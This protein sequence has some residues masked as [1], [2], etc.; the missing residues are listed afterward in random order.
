MTP[1]SLSGRQRRSF[2]LATALW[3]PVLLVAQLRA[4]SVPPLKWGKVTPAEF[5]LKTCPYDSSASAVVLSDYGRIVFGYGVLHIERHKRTK[6]LNR[7]GL[8]AATV[9]I[10]Y[11]AE[12]NFEKITGLKAQAIAMDDKGRPVVRELSPREVFTLDHP[13]NWKEKRFTFPNVKAGD[14]L[15]Y[16][17]TTLSRNFYTLESWC[18]QSDIPTLHSEL[19][20]EKP[21]GLNYRI[22]LQG[23]ALSAKYAKLTVNQWSLDNLPALAREPHVAYPMDYAERITFQVAMYSKPDGAL[24]DIK[25]HA[26]FMAHRDHARKVLAEV[27]GG[28]DTETEKV[29]KIH[30]Y[31]TRTFR[32]NNSY[33]ILANQSFNALLDTRN[34]NSAEVNLYLTLLLREAGL[35]AYPALL[36][37]CDHG[38]LYVGASP[39]LFQFNQLAAHVELAGKTLLLDATHPLRPY[40][41]PDKNDLNGNAYLLEPDKQ[42]WVE[43]QPAAVTRQVVSEEIDLADPSRPTRRFSVRY[44][45]YDAV[46]ER[47]K[48]AG[49]GKFVPERE[50]IE[51]SYSRFKLTHCET[52][53]LDDPDQPLLVNL[54]YQAE[55]PAEA[56]PGMLYFAPLPL[57]KFAENPFQN[58]PRHLPVELGYASVYTYVLN[59]KVPPGYQ[60]QEVPKST[61]IKMP[62]NLARFRYEVVQQENVVQLSSTVHFTEPVIPAENY[63][64]LREFYD[65]VIAK[66]REVIVLKKQ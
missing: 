30:N 57:T 55:A 62:G 17:Y 53:A 7:H 44:E 36:S 13:G 16:K 2:F 39:F 15:E 60:L 37:T 54:A 26:T 20:T 9:S 19:K 3:L 56:Q 42:R 33:G 64:H 59:L 1:F 21:T 22:L 43:V 25:N 8:E 40:T 38:K 46:A 61:L 65:Q 5:G 49:K 32:W 27:L 34:G 50:E 51:T 63:H 28:D 31:V 11:Y 24:V 12:D 48:H 6:I 10:P 45:G 4:Q 66:Y 23:K 14:I 47:R 52:K 29:R 18:F 35:K 58:Q 41:L